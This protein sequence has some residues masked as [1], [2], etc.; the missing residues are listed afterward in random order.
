[1]E[2]IE[3]DTKTVA[4]YLHDINADGRVAARI[5][6]VIRFYGNILGPATLRDLF[7]SES[8]DP[9]GTRQYGSVWLFFDTFIC[10]AK[11]FLPDNDFD[12]SNVSRNAIVYWR[13]QAK[14]FDFDK[15]AEGSRIGFRIDFDNRVNCEMSATGKNC[16]YFMAVFRK[17][18]RPDA[19]QAPVRKTKPDRTPVPKGKQS[20]V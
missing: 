11:N 5:E 2:A 18:F 6:D 20:L 1:M 12:F 19:A 13:V 14:D 3:Y 15:S 16:E 7:V 10:E 8:V 17:Y 4:G 9:D